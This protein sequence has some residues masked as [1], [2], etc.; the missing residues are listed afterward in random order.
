MKQ[1]LE[2]EPEAKILLVSASPVVK[3]VSNVTRLSKT[4]QDFIVV[5][6]SLKSFRD[7]HQSVA[8]IQDIVINVQP[9]EKVR[10]KI[11]FGNELSLYEF[12]MSPNLTFHFE[13]T[14]EIMNVLL[15]IFDRN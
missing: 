9:N 10:N 13:E 7:V 14:W 4:L 8:V 6:K 5:E 3:E 15:G 11:Y 2:L 12:K 1:I